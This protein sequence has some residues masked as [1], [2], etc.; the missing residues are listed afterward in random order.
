M[1]QIVNVT[2]QTSRLLPQITKQGKTPLGKL[3][4]FSRHPFQEVEPL[5][6]WPNNVNLHIGEIGK[7][8]STTV[9]F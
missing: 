2:K 9:P 6:P 5:R 3:D 1:S 7:M 4:E 8:T